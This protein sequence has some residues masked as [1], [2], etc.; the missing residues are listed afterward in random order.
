MSMFMC[1]RCDQFRDSD[2][3]CEDFGRNLVC[4]ECAEDIREESAAL[5]DG[6]PINA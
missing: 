3:G 6:E 1:A 4:L 5:S 2:D